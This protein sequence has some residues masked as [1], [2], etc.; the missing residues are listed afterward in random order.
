MIT[1][2]LS[3]ARSNNRNSSSGVIAIDKKK[4]QQQ[5]QQNPSPIL[6]TET[7]V[8]HQTPVLF[9]TN[10][11]L[12]L[13]KANRSCSAFAATTVSVAGNS[14][15]NSKGNAYDLSF[16]DLERWSTNRANSVCLNDTINSQT[17]SLNYQNKPLLRFSML[18]RNITEDYDQESAFN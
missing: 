13:R 7:I 1:E 5:I 6:F 2:N 15:N 17:Y 11:G 3:S 14:S 12:F 16:C 10:R 18:K 9:S 4:E 8:S